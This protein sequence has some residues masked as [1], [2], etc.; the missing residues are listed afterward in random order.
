[1]SAPSFSAPASWRGTHSRVTEQRTL[2]ANRSRRFDW[3]HC[4]PL[5]SVAC[6]AVS[7]GFL[8]NAYQSFMVTD[9]LSMILFGVASLPFGA[10]C[11]YFLAPTSPKHPE[12]KTLVEIDPVLADLNR[13]EDEARAKHGNVVSIQKAK[14]ARLHAILA[15]E[16]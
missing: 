8:A 1:M 12:P 2:R 7:M 13:Q 6:G 15:G 9:D 10:L 14:R 11:G 16:V 4:R 5:I 3:T